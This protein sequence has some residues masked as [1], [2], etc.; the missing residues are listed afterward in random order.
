MTGFKASNI[1]GA[2]NANGQVFLINPNGVLIGQGAQVNVGGLVASTRGISDEDFADGRYQFSGKS[3]VE[4]IN[5]GKITTAEGG[6]VALL[7]ARV[8]NNGE[9]VANGG[10]VALAAGN[11]FTLSLGN[12]NLISLQ[13]NAAAAD[14]LAQNTSLLKVMAVRC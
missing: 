11:D 12:D 1:Q 10:A 5:D 13:I 9:I 3:A 2:L 8:R 6:Y 14:A 7:G 4:V